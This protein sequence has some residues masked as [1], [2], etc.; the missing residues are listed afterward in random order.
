MDFEKGN[1]ANHAAPGTDNH[2]NR[3]SSADLGSYHD[4]ALPGGRVENP[5]S[6]TQ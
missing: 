3:R 6:Q 2:R 5:L 4:G 1:R